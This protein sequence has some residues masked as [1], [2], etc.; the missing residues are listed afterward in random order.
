MP[1]GIYPR[2]MKLHMKRHAVTQPLDASYRLI[3]LT[4]G[5]NTIVDVEDFEFLSQWNWLARKKK[6]TGRFHVGRYE[7]TKEGKRVVAMHVVIMGG[8]A[9]HKNRNGLDNRRE[10]LRPCTA[11]QN[12]KNRSLHRNNKSGFKGVCWNKRRRKW[13][14]MIGF[15]WDQKEIGCFKTKE[16]AALA[17]NEAAKRFHGEFASLNILPSSLVLAG[18]SVSTIPRNMPK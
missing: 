4:Q 10:N 5:Q 8:P 16:A 6:S 14:A 9:D 11:A 18:R 12:S 1:R 3:P 17:Y 15:N 13:T 2:R 7:I